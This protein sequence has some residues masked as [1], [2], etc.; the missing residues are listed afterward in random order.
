V[1]TARSLKTYRGATPT[2]PLPKVHGLSRARP[3]GFV[4]WQTLRRWGKLPS[5]ELGVVGYLLRDIRMQAK[6]TQKQLAACLGVSQQAVA[7]AERWDANPTV[8]IL[9]R[10]A[11]ACGTTL[12]VSFQQSARADEFDEFRGTNSRRQG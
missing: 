11:E 12:T 7:Q 6:L 2:V 10:W 1:G 8:N 5:W 9:R 3:R 4:E